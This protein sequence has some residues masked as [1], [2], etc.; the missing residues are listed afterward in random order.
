MTDHPYSRHAAVRSQQR[1]VPA[2]LVR[3]ILEHHDVDEHAGGGCRVLR[4][5]RH[6]LLG[7][8]DGMTRQDEGR[9][10]G[11]A[12]LYSETTGHLVT[13]LRHRPGRAGRRYRRAFR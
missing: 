12:V 4:L 7:D 2:H 6:A 8:V 5:S 11:L 10:S 1:G 9:L 3:L 13:V